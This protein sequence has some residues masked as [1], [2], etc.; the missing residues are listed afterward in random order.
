MQAAVKEFDSV[1]VQHSDVNHSDTE[2]S[3]ATPSNS[4]DCQSYSFLTKQ[5][6]D[7]EVEEGTGLSQWWDFTL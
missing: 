7:F 5:K 4:W 1:P 3:I 2:I 6:V